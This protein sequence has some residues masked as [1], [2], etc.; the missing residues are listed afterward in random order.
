MELYEK[1]RCGTEFKM[2][3]EVG[4]YISNGGKLDSNG[5]KYIIQRELRIFRELHK[6]CIPKAEK[7]K[8][9]DIRDFKGPGIKEMG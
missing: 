7:G 2:V 5:D 3:D 9:I 8:T 1:C 6:D 4:L